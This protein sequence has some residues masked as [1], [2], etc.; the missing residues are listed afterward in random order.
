MMP[1]AAAAWRAR[2]VRLSL[3]KVTD[4][5]ADG[6]EVLAELEAAPQREI[7]RRIVVRITA[8][9]IAELVGRVDGA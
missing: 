3:H 8:H 5:G 2:V 9:D 1:R 6:I 7:G 4:G